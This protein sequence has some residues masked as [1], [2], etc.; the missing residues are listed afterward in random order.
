MNQQKGVY[1]HNLACMRGWM[2]NILAKGGEIL[3]LKNSK[4]QY[5]LHMSVHPFPEPSLIS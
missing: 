1:D 4:H 5:A 2:K 3:K